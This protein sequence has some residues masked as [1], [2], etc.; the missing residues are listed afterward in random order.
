MITVIVLLLIA[1]LVCGLVI[2]LVRFYDTLRSIASRLRV[3]RWSHGPRSPSS[4]I[5][6]NGFRVAVDLPGRRQ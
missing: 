4:T 1:G 2:G 3:Y 6:A 5:R